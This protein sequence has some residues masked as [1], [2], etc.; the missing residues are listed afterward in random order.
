MLYVGIPA[1]A[2]VPNP[3]RSE[4][5]GACH[6]LLLHL[7]MRHKTE[8][9]LGDFLASALNSVGGLLRKEDSP[10]IDWKSEE[11]KEILAA[12]MGRLPPFLVECSASIHPEVRASVA[13][14]LSNVKNWM[15]LPDPLTKTLARLAKDNRARVRARA[16]HKANQRGES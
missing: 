14:L 16:A 11:G 9:E 8:P 4:L 1:A 6:S 5:I 3:T 10:F 7:W 15:Q 2:F 12:L 13:M